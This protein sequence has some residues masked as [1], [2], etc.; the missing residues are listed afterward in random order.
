MYYAMVYILWDRCLVEDLPG[1]K[2]QKYGNNLIL[3]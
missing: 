2:T 3:G 1:F